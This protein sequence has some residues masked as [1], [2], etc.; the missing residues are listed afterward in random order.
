[1]SGELSVPLPV[2]LTEEVI[3]KGGLHF[4]ITLDEMELTLHLYMEL[5]ITELTQKPCKNNT[6]QSRLRC[7]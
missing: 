2:S 6:G 5:A 7:N 4:P 1:M 3:Q